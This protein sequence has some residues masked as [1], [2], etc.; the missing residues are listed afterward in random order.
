MPRSVTRSVLYSFLYAV[1][2]DSATRDASQT[3]SQHVSNVYVDVGA[4]PALYAAAVALARPGVLS[5]AA[6]RKVAELYVEQGRHAGAGLD[7]AARGHIVSLFKR[8]H[9]LERDFGVTI[10]ADSTTMLVAQADANG[11]PPQ[12]V[13]T[14]QKAPSGEYIVPVNEATYRSAHGQRDESPRRARNSSTRISREAVRPTLGAS[15]RRWCCVIRSHTYS[16]F[17][18]WASYQLDT[19]MVKDPAR[20]VAFLDADRLA[21]RREDQDRDREPR[22][23]EA[24]ERRLYAVRRVRLS[25]YNAML[26]RTKY[27]VDPE[28][29]RQYFPVDQVVKGVFGIYEELLGVKLHRDNARRRMGARTCAS[30]PYR[31]RRRR[32]RSDGSFSTCF[33]ARI[34]TTTSRRST[35]AR[36]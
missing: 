35:S 11:I 9:D 30:S 14:L 4:D 7:S 27:K 1:S 20:V 13:A 6:E 28:E 10:A 19:H 24:R 21:A 23:D 12:L 2:P 22:R 17:A 16:A 26:R 34:S 31:T 5:D 8:L 33:R 32:S 29:I 18:N 3:C 15:I 25:Y 36:R